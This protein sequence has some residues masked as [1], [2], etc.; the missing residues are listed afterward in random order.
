MYRRHCCTLIC[1]CNSSIA[2]K[3]CYYVI[4]FELNRVLRTRKRSCVEASKQRLF[5]I[6]NGNFFTLFLVYKKSCFWIFTLNWRH[7]YSWFCRI[8]NR[9]EDII[10][11]TVK[12]RFHRSITSLTSRHTLLLVD[13]FIFVLGPLILLS[14]FWHLNFQRF[15]ITSRRKLCFIKLIT[16]IISFIY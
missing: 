6:I 8:M 16:E 7:W 1:S 3:F 4:L 13:I 2:C 9:S 15:I 10:H 12:K 5:Q 14:F 11:S